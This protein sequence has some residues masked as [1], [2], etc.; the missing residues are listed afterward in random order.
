MARSLN[1][2]D[3]QQ[4]QIR[5]SAFQI[6]TS[7]PSSPTLSCPDSFED[8]LDASPDTHFL[9]PM[10]LY[11][12]A[13]EE[14]DLW[15][16]DDDED[17]SDD[18]EVAWNAGITDFALFDRDRRNAS[19]SHDPVPDKWQALLDSQASALQRAVERN[20]SSSSSTPTERDCTQQG[21]MP[22]MSDLPSLTPD[23][24]PDI[25]DDFDLDAHVAGKVAQIRPLS[26]SEY[27][28][29]RLPTA[30]LP[31]CKTQRPDLSNLR[32]ASAPITI[33][34]PSPYDFYDST[35]SEGDYD[36]DDD[37]DASTDSEAD[38]PVALLIARA[39]ERRLRERKMQRPGLRGTRTLSGKSHVWRR[40]SWNLPP[41]G[42]EAEIE[43]EAQ[44]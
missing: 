1:L 25:R 32:S 31:S 43:I 44:D 30:A 6:S 13:D 34:R 36:D 37:D 35:G 10:P 24:S 12:Y 19:A 38:L 8:A 22:L 16:Y 5:H 26:V 21:W 33:M 15:S 28:H 11:E 41:L 42:E 29:N 39:Q 40:P 17:E 7:A 23:H 4:S 2:E 9:S 14:N 3:F 18:D 27:L 20:R